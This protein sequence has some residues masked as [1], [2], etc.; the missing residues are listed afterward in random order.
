LLIQRHQ[1]PIANPPIRH[2]AI[3]NPIRNRRST[4]RND[5][6]GHIIRSTM[7][8]TLIALLMSVSLSA[9]EPPASIPLWPS[10]AP[11]SEGKT[12]KE[13]V[14]TSESGEQRVSSIHIPSITP[15]LP[16]REKATGAAILVIPGGGHR[17]LAITHEGYNVAEWLA[18]RGIA[19][20]VLKHRLAREEGS[21]YKIEVESFA[22][23]QRA[24]R[25]IR[26]R[27]AEWNI[28]PSRVGAL[29][30][31][32]GGELVN[33]ISTRADTGMAGSA[34]AIERQPFKPDFQALIYPGRSADIQPVK[35]SPP[36]FLACA[37]NDRTDISEGLAEAYLRF[38]RAGVP[39]E[40]HV[41]GTGGHGFGLRAKNTR[42]VGAWNAR[43]EEWLA[44]SG[45]LKKR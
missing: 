41:Y 2:S 39:A 28:D 25:L 21:T 20:F 7:P 18:A 32:A 1:S 31:S 23:A 44:E 19:A 16:P 33:Q 43:F 36:A 6:P 42:P 14:A 34:D 29:G 3:H 24:M 9:A 4:I 40:L 17:L 13:V 30:F 26:S 45:M 5:L 22:D 11:G 15:Y 38:K 12:A 27:A 8:L 37:Y 10:G 35:E